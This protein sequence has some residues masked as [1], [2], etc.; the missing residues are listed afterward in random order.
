MSQ[1]KAQDRSANQRVL[2]TRWSRAALKRGP[3]PEIGVRHVPRSLRR[4]LAR[5]GRRNTDGRM[6]SSPADPSRNVTTDSNP[7]SR[8]FLTG[9]R[10][11]GEGGW[12]CGRPVFQRSGGPELFIFIVEKGACLT[13][14]PNQ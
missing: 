6:E 4:T 9:R 10:G 11:P 1:V 8:T 14:V 13:H 7:D 3:T 2:N 12:R 5:I